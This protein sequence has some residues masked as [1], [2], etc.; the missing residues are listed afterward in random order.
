MRRI[1]VVFFLMLM[2][3]GACAQ[4]KGGYGKDFS[5][6]N[7]LLLQKKYA[8]ALQCFMRAY[9]TDSSSANISYKIGCCYLGLTNKRDLA[10]R[11]FERAQKDVSAIYNTTNPLQIAAPRNTYYYLGMAYHYTSRFGEAI[12]SFK[13]YRQYVLAKDSLAEID[14]RIEQ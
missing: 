10:I 11:Y 6:G 3:A 13:T 5:Q 4:D 2:Y 1:Y 8:Q 12:N 14:H 9:N 7:S